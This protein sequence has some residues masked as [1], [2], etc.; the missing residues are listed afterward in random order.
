MR[1]RAEGLWSL[2]ERTAKG[3]SQ[4]DHAKHDQS[5]SLR[6]LAQPNQ[7]TRA[8]SRDENPVRRKERMRLEMGRRR[9]SRCDEA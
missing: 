7:H 2:A 9:R 4:R 6:H 1:T 3:G 5:L 8:A